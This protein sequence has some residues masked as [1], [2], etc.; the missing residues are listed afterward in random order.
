MIHS[1]QSVVARSTVVM[2]MENEEDRLVLPVMTLPMAP[3]Q[4]TIDEVTP[5]SLRVQNHCCSAQL[6]IDWGSS[7]PFLYHRSIPIS[8]PNMISVP[9]TRSRRL[10][11]IINR[12]Y[13]SA[14][15]LY[16]DDVIYVIKN[17]ESQ[18]SSSEE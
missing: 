12:P 15:R 16:Y 3:S 11:N 1:I 7:K 17:A 2:T 18:E 10:T 13:V 4:F 5:R 6:F 9:F 8:L 14:V